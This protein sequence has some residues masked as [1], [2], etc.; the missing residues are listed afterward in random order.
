MKTTWRFFLP[1]NY[2]KEL[3][4]INARSREGFHLVKST[5][6][7]RREEADPNRCWYYRLDYREKSGYTE[8]LH[9]KQGWE[10][11]CRQGSYLWFRKE[12]LEGRP[13]SDYELHGEH[14][15]LEHHFRAVVKRLDAL[16]NLLLILTVP[17][18][19]LPAELTANWTP[20]AACIPLFLAILPV[21]AAGEFRKLFGEEK[22]SQ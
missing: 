21:K 20:R 15:A 13:D 14:H 1:W 18:I 11:V 6:F 7:C 10:P 5:R 19:L 3:D 8:L 16:R 4:A 12:V 22:K 17:L 2:I 9:E